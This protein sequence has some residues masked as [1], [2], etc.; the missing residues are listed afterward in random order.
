MLMD[1]RFKLCFLSEAQLLKRHLTTKK[2][3]PE[4]SVMRELAERLRKAAENRDVAELAAKVSVTPMTLYRWLNA[5]F[6]PGIVKLS[7]LAEILGV[8]LAWLTAGVGPMEHRRAKLHARLAD[9]GRT[10]YVAPEGGSEAPPIAFLEPWLFGLLYGSSNDSRTLMPGDMKPPLLFNVPDDAMAPT[11][12]RG[13][14]V[15]V[16][17]SFALREMTLA[18]ASSGSIYDGV[19]LFRL[20]PTPRG[21]EAAQAQ[22]LLRRVL[23]RLDGTMIVRCDNPKYSEKET[24]AP[25]SRN[26]PTPIGRAVWHADRI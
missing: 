7:Q 4:S 25:R 15:L 8:S 17:R 19:Y 11:F 23:Y 2:R 1:K 3:S 18:Q 9:Y 10:D 13:A 21:S 16:D 24:Y 26:R 20:A 5:K 6:D 12:M 22:L 14:L